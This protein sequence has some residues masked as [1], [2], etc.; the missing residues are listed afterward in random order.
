LIQVGTIEAKVEKLE[1]LINKLRDLALSRGIKIGDTKQLITM[2]RSNGNDLNTAIATLY[3]AATK[4]LNQY[5]GDLSLE[6]EDFGAIEEY[7]MKNNSI[8]NSNV[9]Q[10]GFMFQKSIDKIANDMVSRYSP[11]RD[12]FMKFYE[13]AGYTKTQNAIIGNQASVY[14]NLYEKDE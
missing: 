1:L 10:I 9:R 8:A 11:I 13:D 3:L 4:A 12:I 5:F 2:S 7:M 6:N 14:L